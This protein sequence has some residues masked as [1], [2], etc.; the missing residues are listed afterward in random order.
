MGKPAVIK[1]AG[2]YLV[3]VIEIVLVARFKR[4]LRCFLKKYF[5]LK[6]IFIAFT[7][8]APRPFFLR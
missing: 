3:L 8:V 5:S 6:K 2:S 4:A 1:W 7:C